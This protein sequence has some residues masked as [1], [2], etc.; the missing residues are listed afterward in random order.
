MHIQVNLNYKIPAALKLVLLW[1][2]FN[3]MRQKPI[4]VFKIGTSSITDEHG[5]LDSTVVRSVVKQL[6][7]L[8]AHYHIVIVSS[9]AVGTGK[10]YIRHYSGKIVERKA[11]AAIGN[12]ILLHKYAQLFAK[13]TISI[14]QSLCERSHFSDREKF[15]QL[16]D[17]YEELWKNGVIP[18]ANENDVVSSRELK[19][20]DNDE[21]ATL[22][23]VGF[24]AQYLLIGTSVSG[25]L[26][27]QGNVLPSIEKFDESVLSL[28]N[29]ETSSSGLGGMISKL[30]FAHLA[31]SMGIKVV[32]FS[33]REKNGIAKAIKEKTGTICFPRSVSK[34]ARQKWLATGSVAIGSIEVDEGAH[35][36]LLKRKSL[37]MVG[38]KNINSDFGKG[39]A[40][41]IN[42]HEGKTFAVARAKMSSAEA[43]KNM[44]KRNLVLAHADDIVLI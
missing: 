41:E 12:P 4:L 8:H 14:A 30:T 42:N 27:K 37:L 44:K 36:A 35:K 24:G 26:D 34:S 20:S 3:R 43:A 7:A 15:L 29:K 32:I 18:I 13:H 1:I 19:F 5:S 40:F 31:T 2:K 33:S 38:V 17:T 10:K 28:A 23:A 25:V 11:A 9:G 39:E 21:L 22:L 16:R 6:A